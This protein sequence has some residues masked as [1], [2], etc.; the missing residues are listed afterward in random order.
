M[1]SFSF[2]TRTEPASQRP[3]PL[4]FLVIT[5]AAVALVAG[6]AGLLLGILPRDVPASHRLISATAL[7]SIGLA[8]LTVQL[9][10]KPRL[11]E[12]LRRLMVAS[13]FI[14]WGID[15]LLPPGTLA[16]VIGDLVIGL[17]VVDLALLVKDQLSPTSSSDTIL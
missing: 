1:T 13:A 9:L 14:L 16:D 7:L 4:F 10:A 17:Y 8:Y 3:K 11:Q 5:L 15:Q 2:L 6:L 12:L